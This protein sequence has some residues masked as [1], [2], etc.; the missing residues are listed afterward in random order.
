MANKNLD[1]LCAATGLKL[2]PHSG[3]AY[4]TYHGYRVCVTPPANNNMMQMAFSVSR[5]GASPDLAALRQVC[6]TCREIASVQGSGSQVVF[7]VR[8]AMNWNKTLENAETALDAAAEQLRQGGY[9]D[10]CQHCGAA[11]D[12]TTCLLSGH[13]VHLCDACAQSMTASAAA[14]R[15]AAAEK[16]ENVL[17][18]VVG[19]LLGSL[20]GAATIVILSQLGVVAAL[21]GIVM[22]VCTLKGYEL[23]GGKLTKKGV[24]ISVLVMLLMVY[25]GDRCDWA[26][27]VAREMEADFFTSF[28]AVPALM[29]M[30]IIDTGV[31][32]S[33]LLRVYL[34]TLVGA[35]PMILS[36][37]KGKSRKNETYAM[38]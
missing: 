13:P 32:M 35:V 24:V 11:A 26:I 3:A 7:F 23:L 21:S 34:F 4:G 33:S 19:A 27:V 29:D 10:C 25:V 28:R 15:Q 38:K 22:A 31:Y 30:D 18:G 9:Q 12:L 36:L 14:Q 20:I 2:D 5:G 17:G 16:P 6:G 1:A 8:S 37:M